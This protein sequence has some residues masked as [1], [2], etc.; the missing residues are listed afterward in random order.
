VD[1]YVPKSPKYE[2][3]VEPASFNVNSRSPVQVTVSSKLRMTAKCTIC[4]IIVCEQDQTYSAIE[5]KLE[6]KPSMWIDIDEV[7]MTEE[8]LG[9]GG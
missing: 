8:F 9:G 1:I 7:K 4:L 6:S 2:I 5:F 3:V